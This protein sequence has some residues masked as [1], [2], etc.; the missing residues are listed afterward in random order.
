MAQ[1]MSD[2][3]VGFNPNSKSNRNGDQSQRGGLA[4]SKGGSPVAKPRGGGITGMPLGSGI[5][6]KRAIDPTDPGVIQAGLDFE[7][8]MAEKRRLAATNQGLTLSNPFGLLGGGGV[9]KKA[10]L[11]AS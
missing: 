7:R 5:D 2:L 9:T 1:T 11:G 3:L 6:I 4:S 8:R 10:L